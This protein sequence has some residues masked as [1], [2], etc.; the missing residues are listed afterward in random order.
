MSKPSTNTNYDNLDKSDLVFQNSLA[1]VKLAV[2]NA[3]ANPIKAPKKTRQP[4]ALLNFNNVSVFDKK[5]KGDIDTCS[6]VVHKMIFSGK[7]NI[8]GSIDI[9]NMVNVHKFELWSYIYYLYY[10]NNTSVEEFAAMRNPKN[11]TASAE[12][13]Y[14]TVK[15]VVD[16]QFVYN[17]TNTGKKEIVVSMDPRTLAY[18]INSMVH[19]YN[20]DLA[21]PSVN[22]L[23][24]LINESKVARFNS[25]IV[26]TQSN[27][28]NNVKIVPST[29]ANVKID[30]RNV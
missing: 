28:A 9:S 27:G 5:F 24:T 14:K 13:F 26:K 11:G 17:L 29:N 3:K 19:K 21:N 8:D 2:A 20:K 10:F 22:Y 16:N 12:M 25:L 7:I 30:V 18:F 15:A 23:E 4:R 6:C 1:K